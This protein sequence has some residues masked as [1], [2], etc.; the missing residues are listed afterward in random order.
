MC[1]NEDAAFEIFKVGDPGV[2]TS[3]MLILRD[4]TFDCCFLSGE[5]FDL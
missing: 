2:S 5:E 4:R 3:S 1:D